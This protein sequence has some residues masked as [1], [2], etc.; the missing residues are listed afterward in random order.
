MCGNV[1]NVWWTSG[2]P[3]AFIKKYRVL[4]I[5]SQRARVGPQICTWKMHFRLIVMEGDWGTHLRNVCPGIGGLVWGSSHHTEACRGVAGRWCACDDPAWESLGDRLQSGV[6]VKDLDLCVRWRG[7]LP[8]EGSGLWP[9]MSA[10]TPQASETSCPVGVSL[11][12]GPLA[13]IQPHGVM[14]G[15]AFGVH[16]ISS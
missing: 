5:I 3:V 9:W 16:W 12:A 1:L 2:W 6:R 13:T 15:G 11:F 4:V 8:K 14:H 10:V 7:T